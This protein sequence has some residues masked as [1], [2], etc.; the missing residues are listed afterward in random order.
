MTGDLDLD[1]YNY[2]LPAGL[3][4]TGFLYFDGYN[5]TLPAGLSTT[6]FLYLGGYNYPLPAGLT[7]KIKDDLFSV[8]ALA[9]QEV[10]ALQKALRA[11]KIDGSM[12][13]SECCCF[14]GTLE[15]AGKLKLPHNST[16]AAEK[17]FFPIRR[18]DT[19]ATNTNA[20]YADQ[21]ITEFLSKER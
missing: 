14:V 8:L 10:S 13:E 15:K 12:Y 11:G 20:F 6:G 5:Y 4:T 17:W 16:R 21:W 7:A 1:G 19:P 9:P 2:P 3:T 18:G